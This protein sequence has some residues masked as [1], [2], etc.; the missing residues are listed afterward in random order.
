M[1]EA[2]EE[3]VILIRLFGEMEIERR[4]RLGEHRARERRD[5]A[6]RQGLNETSVLA[7]GYT[8]S[9]GSIAR[10][11]VLGPTPHGLFEQHGGRAGVARYLTRLLGDDRHVTDRHD[12]E[13]EEP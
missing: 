12:D 11:G 2:I 7:S 13:H 4:Q 8:A 6:G 1:L 9:G 10:V 5:S 3:Q